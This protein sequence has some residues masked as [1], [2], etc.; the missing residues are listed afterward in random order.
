M[1]RSRRIQENKAS[2]SQ[3]T[4]VGEISKEPTAD[5]RI[6]T[7]TVHDTTEKRDN[8]KPATRKRANSNVQPSNTETSIKK[9]RQRMPE[10]FRKVRGKLGLL[11]RLAKDMPLDVIFEV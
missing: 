1:R 4:L 11:E 10:E 7:R 3:S 5:D 6:H 8:T 2:Q 9:K